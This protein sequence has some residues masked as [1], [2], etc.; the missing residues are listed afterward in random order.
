M[1]A[2]ALQGNYI[3]STS[4]ERS[5][6]RLV[7]NASGLSGVNGGP[8]SASEVKPPSLFFIHSTT[9]DVPEA[10]RKQ[11]GV[12]RANGKIGLPAKSSQHKLSFKK[13]KKKKNEKNRSWIYNTG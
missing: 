5:S 8:V 2:V 11:R 9:V 13:H 1:Y 12:F 6:S 10:L 7:P 4:G 3:S